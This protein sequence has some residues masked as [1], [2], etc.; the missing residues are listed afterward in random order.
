LG[1][2]PASSPASVL[3]ANDHLL[4]PGPM[5]DRSKPPKGAVVGYVRVSTAEQADSGLG[6]G[7]QRAAIEAE[8]RRRG[9]ALGA[10]YEDAGASARG[11]AGRPA[12]SEALAA[13]ERG[14]AMT[15]V[16]AKL[17][18]LTRSVRDAADLL[19][20]AERGGWSLV[21][22]DL[23]VDTTTPSGEAMANVMAVFAQLERRLIGQRTRDALAIRRAQGVRLGRPRQLPQAV[24]ERIV[25]NRDGGSGWSA[26][27]RELD[28][29]GVPTAQGGAHWYPATVRAVYLAHSGEAA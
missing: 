26:I 1:K 20:R 21:A 15:L 19:E 14:D 5:T 7:A 23:G 12:L 17:D 8:C 28:S 29:D 9:W 22:L 4:Y 25:S 13:L 11:L 10:V 2:A 18:R 16:V 3:I 24:V 27:A 6:L